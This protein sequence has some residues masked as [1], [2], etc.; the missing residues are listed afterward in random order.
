MLAT[1]LTLGNVTLIA[2]RMTSPH[3]LFFLQK[4]YEYYLSISNENTKI[5]GDVL[6]TNKFNKNHPRERGNVLNHLYLP[7]IFV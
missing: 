3:Q 1:L 4:C 2:N 5:K 7:F 6:Q